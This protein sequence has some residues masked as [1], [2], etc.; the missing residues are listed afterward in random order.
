MLTPTIVAKV[1]QHDADLLFRP[2]RTPCLPLGGE[3][4][5]RL[6]LPMEPIWFFDSS[7]TISQSSN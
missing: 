4:W 2:M 6:Q 5:R 3:N 1:A 7:N